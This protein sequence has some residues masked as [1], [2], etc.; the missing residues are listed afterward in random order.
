VGGRGCTLG[1]PNAGTGADG[2]PVN[3]EDM[4]GFA[5]GAPAGSAAVACCRCWA[6]IREDRYVSDASSWRMDSKPVPRADTSVLARVVPSA[7]RLACTPRSS[8]KSSALPRLPLLLRTAGAAAAAAVMASP[9]CIMLPKV[10]LPLERLRLWPAVAARL[11]GAKLKL[12]WRLEA[13]AS[14][15]LAELLS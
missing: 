4:D 2:S 13:P 7:S 5:A 3:M 11:P 8:A 12:P 1:L 9:L 14:P 6:C 15:P 10:P